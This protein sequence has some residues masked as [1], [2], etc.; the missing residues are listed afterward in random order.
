MSTYRIDAILAH[1][2]RTGVR[3][4]HRHLI[5]ARGHGDDA[6]ARGLE[7]AQGD[8]AVLVFG[9]HLLPLLHLGDAGAAHC[10]QRIGHGLTTLH[11]AQFDKGDGNQARTPEAP[12]GLGH[13]P[14]GV[15]LRDHD[16]RFAGVRIQFVGSLSLE[17]IL[18]DSI[19]HGTLTF[20]RRHSEGALSR[21]GGG[22]GRVGGGTA[23]GE[24]RV[25]VLFVQVH[26]TPTIPFG[27]A[28]DLKE[29][30]GHEPSGTRDERIAGLVPVGIVLSTDHVEK[31]SLAEAEFLGGARLWCIIVEGFDD[32]C[33]TTRARWKC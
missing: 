19:D 13:E 25:V 33:A 23:I 24:A 5:H 20:E 6:A 21:V 16:N 22:G 11:V 29:G 3:C 15:G 27:F 32:L 2:A 4:A 8:T 9:G 17:I 14:F 31:V 12:D 26:G 28:D 10:L 30:D 7:L 1:A 18:D